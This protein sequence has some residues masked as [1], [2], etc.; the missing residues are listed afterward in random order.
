MRTRRF[1]VAL[2][3]LS[4]PFLAGS[5]FAVANSVSSTP[6]PQVIIPSRTS[7]N[8]PTT[9][10]HASRGTGKDDPAGHDTTADTKARTTA[11]TTPDDHGRDVAGH[12]ATDDQG[13]DATTPTSVSDDGPGH[14]AND[15]QGQDGTTTTTVTMP[16]SN[17]HDGTG[18]NAPDDGAN[19]DQTDSGSGQDGSG[20]DG[21][22]SGSGH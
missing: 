7:S 10:Q 13:H 3:A 8:T 20:H 11:G 19:H 1:S 21:G 22:T 4:I 18:D 17:D 2:A 9:A 15:D 16:D 14:D 12:D 6:G 5:A